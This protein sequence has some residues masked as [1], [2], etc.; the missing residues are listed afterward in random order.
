[1][2]GN[3]QR[4]VQTGPVDPHLCDER[5]VLVTHL[6]VEIFSPVVGVADKHLSVQHGSVAELRTVPA[7]QQAP[8]QLALVHHGRH[9]KACFFQG[10]LPELEA[11]ELGHDSQVHLYH[12]RE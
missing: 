3:Y 1:M 2:L 8:R 9:H 7:A 10:F 4:A 6:I 12:Y 11:L 5:S